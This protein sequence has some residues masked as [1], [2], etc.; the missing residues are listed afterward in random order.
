MITS[1]KI[2]PLFAA[3][4]ATK[5]DEEILVIMLCLDIVILCSS[6]LNTSFYLFSFFLPLPPWNINFYNPKVGASTSRDSIVATTIDQNI[7]DIVTY[8]AE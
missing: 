3:V 5:S 2:Y 7:S 1:H 8:T 4:S 6:S